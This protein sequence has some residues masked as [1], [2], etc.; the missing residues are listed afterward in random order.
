MPSSVVECYQH[1]T[2]MLVTFYQTTQHHTPEHCGL[3]TRAGCWQHIS[4]QYETERIQIQCTC[5]NH[6]KLER[7]MNLLSPT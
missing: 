5:E 2:G 6:I 1:F 7:T 3:N 4:K